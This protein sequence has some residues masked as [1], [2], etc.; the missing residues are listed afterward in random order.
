MHFEQRGHMEAQQ[1]K[2]AEQGWSSFFDRV[3]QRLA[4][5]L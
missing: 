1:Y 3:E 4:D 5:A 2:R